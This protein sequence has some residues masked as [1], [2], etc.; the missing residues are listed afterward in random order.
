MDETT[1][2]YLLRCSECGALMDERHHTIWSKV[3]GWEKK[4]DAGGTNHVALRIPLGVFMCVG[5]MDKLRSG[6][7]A[8]QLSLA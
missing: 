3:E 6:V 8:S 5:C 7:A 1:N 4:R 2:P